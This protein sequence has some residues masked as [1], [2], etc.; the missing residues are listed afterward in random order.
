MSAQQPPI[1]QQLKELH[2]ENQQ[3]RKQLDRIEKHDKRVKAAQKQLLRGGWRILLPLIDRQRV[4]RSFSKLTSTASEF[5][6][7]RDEWPPKEQVLVDARAFLE[8]YVRFHIRRRT[9]VVLFTLLAATV[10]GIQIWLVYQQN[11]IIETQTSLAQIQVYDVVASSMTEG[12][13]NARMMT[14][15]LLANAELDFLKGVVEEAFGQRNDVVYRAQSVNAAKRRLHDAAFRGHLAR[16]VVSNVEL[17]GRKRELS[18]EEIHEKARPMFRQILEDG[19]DRLP[20]VLRL[21]RQTEAIDEEMAEEVDYYVLQMGSL[22]RVYGRLAR[23]ADEEGEF[24]ADIRPLI[25]NLSARNPN[26]QGRFDSTYRSVM[27][28]FLFDLA[29]APR[30]G[31]KAADLE[32]AGLAPAKALQTGLGRLQKSINSKAINWSS[33]QRQVQL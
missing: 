33:F 2:Q 15:A 18:P 13:R 24:Y 17:Q 28:D 26:T 29:I 10:P 1:E 12:D 4:V 32:S 23:S 25:K 30:F 16:A 8:S 5:T 27:Q 19:S 14:G 31:A 22:L 3:L 11:E 9:L 7:T 6:N 20:I 21:G